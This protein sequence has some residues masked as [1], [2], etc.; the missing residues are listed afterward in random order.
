MAAGA[1][2]RGVRACIRIRKTDSRL[3]GAYTGV[4]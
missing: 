2:H 4:E 1:A 3:G